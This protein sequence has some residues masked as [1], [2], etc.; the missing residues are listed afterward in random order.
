LIHIFICPVALVFEY[1]AIFLPFPWTFLLI[2]NLYILRFYIY[3]TLMDPV[4]RDTECKVI[5]K[6]EDI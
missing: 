2:Q 3:N 6:L 1:T 5:S 4:S